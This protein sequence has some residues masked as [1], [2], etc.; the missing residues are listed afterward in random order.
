MNYIIIN[1]EVIQRSMMGN[2][3]MAKQFVEMYIDQSPI[4]FAALEE[5]F[6]TANPRNIGDCAH[7]I[8]PT[9]EYIGASALRH[10]FQDLENMGNTGTS[11]EIMTQHFNEI[12]PKFELMI[13]ELK[14]FSIE[15]TAALKNEAE[16]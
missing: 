16:M 2:P 13:E 10:A 1:P 4:D 12:K 15:L 3:S 5:S 8:K 6:N 9:M 11:I 14:K 7:H